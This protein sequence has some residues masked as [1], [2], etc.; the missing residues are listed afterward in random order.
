MATPTRNRRTADAMRRRGVPPS[1]GTLRARAMPLAWVLAGLGVFLAV[2]WLV[3]LR[4]DNI[5]LL[6]P[7]DVVFDRLVEMTRDGTMQEH[8]AATLRRLGLGY[9]LG[10]VLGITVGLLMAWQRL[11]GDLLDVTI[12]YL[13]PV[14]AI[15][16]IPLALLVFGIG[17][18]L[19][20]TL[21]AYS[22]FFPFVLNTISGVRQTPRALVEA[23][24]TLGASRGMLWRHVLLPAALPSVLV[25]AKVAMGLAWMTVVAAEL[26]GG[27]SGLG[28]MIMQAATFSVSVGILA[29]MVVIA[30]L[31]FVTIKG[32]EWLDRRLSPWSPGRR[33]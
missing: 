5:V 17:E 12:T 1:S 2:W 11:V 9:A 13:R 22:T 18:L 23:A 10:A 15:A 31:S 30:V 7:P 14:P 4:I 16:L 21:I 26:V 8:A 3:S 29:G 33:A 32:F 19:P 27:S 25:A 28:F 6:P 24:L 20:I